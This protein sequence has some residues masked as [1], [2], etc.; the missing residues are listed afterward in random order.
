MRYRSLNEEANKW[1]DY[2]VKKPADEKEYD[3]MLDFASWIAETLKD[4]SRKYANSSAAKY[5]N[6]AII[7]LDKASNE[8]F[9]LRNGYQ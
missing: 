5:L 6:Q 9:K 2:S 4:S 8:T 7:A 1:I 3:L